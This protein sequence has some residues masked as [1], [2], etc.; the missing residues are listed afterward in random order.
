LKKNWFENVSK[1]GNFMCK[2][3]I[4]LKRAKQRVAT[5]KALLNQTE[6][7]GVWFVQHTTVVDNLKS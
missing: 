6:K 7:N 2:I 1:N 5:V 3:C 4:K